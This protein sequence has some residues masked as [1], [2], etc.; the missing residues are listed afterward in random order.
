MDDELKQLWVSLGD[1]LLEANEG[2]FHEV[3]KGLRDV[4]EAQEI[5]SRFDNQLFFRGR[6]RKV[7]RA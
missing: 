6:P 7:Y 3:M 5:I 2:K 1:R 4:V